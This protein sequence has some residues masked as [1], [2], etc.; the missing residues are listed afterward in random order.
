[1]ADSARA[2][3]LEA[4]WGDR[5]RANREQVDRFREVA[6]GRDFYR[7]T[8][9]M[10]RADPFRSGDLV[11]DALVALARPD[12]TWLDIGAGAGRFA[13]PL[14]RVVRSVIAFDPSPGM[15]AGLREGMETSGISNVEVVNGWWPDDAES[16]A[17]DVTLIAHV[18]YDIE[19]IGP[20]VA[21]ME[22][23]ARRLCVAVLMEQPPA[24]VAYPFW[25]PVHGE[26]RVPLPA[27]PE[28]VELLAARGRA[29]TVQ[30]VAGEARH[31]HSR[32]DM[33]PA[34][35]QQLWVEPDSTKDRRLAALVEA[36]PR[37]ADG[38]ITLDSPHRDIGIVTW[39][40]PRRE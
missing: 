26:E 34:L 38:S 7:P 13:L 2:A 37:N 16:L 10:F 29:A 27:L 5:V 21:A 35:R 4:A 1:V 33:L 15:L 6:D 22:S 39:E 40:P 20:F 19:A 11:L 31:W 12:D 28:F 36:L 3:A 32:D 25:P 17:A 30:R 8:S 18:G 24:G 23:A 14:A 9:A